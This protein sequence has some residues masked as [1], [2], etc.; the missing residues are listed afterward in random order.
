MNYLFLI[1]LAITIS[2]FGA[3]AVRTVRTFSDRIATIDTRIDTIDTRIDSIVHGN[4]GNC[5]YFIQM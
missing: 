2:S 3:F 5:N 1:A 4:P